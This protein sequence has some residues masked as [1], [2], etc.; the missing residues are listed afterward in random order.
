MKVK[1]V[2]TNYMLHQIN[3]ATFKAYKPSL[4]L[5]LKAPITVS[6]TR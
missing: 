2:K 5:V 6:I 4:H 1:L 3:D